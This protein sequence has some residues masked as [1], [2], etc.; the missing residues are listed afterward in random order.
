MHGSEC[1][2]R[3][4]IGSMQRYDERV[5]L[6][7]KYWVY[8]GRGLPRREM[9]QHGDGNVRRQGCEQQACPHRGRT[10]SGFDGIVFPSRRIR[11]LRVRRMRYE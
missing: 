7:G 9:V 5:R 4:P 6:S 2:Y 10:Q 8:D 3:V 1:E 11:G